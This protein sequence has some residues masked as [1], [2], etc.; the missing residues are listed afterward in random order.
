MYLLAKFARQYTKVLLTGEGADEVFLGYK[1]YL[2]KSI[3]SDDDLLFSNSFSTVDTVSGIIKNARCSL[4]EREK[5]IK[6]VVGLDYQDKLSF[7]DM[8]TYLPHV[9]LRQDKAG[10]AANIENRVPF[11]YESVVQAGYNLDLKIGKLGGKTPIKKIA[12]KYFSRDFVMREKCGFG[13]PISE[14]LKD[15]SGLLPHLQALKNS[16]FIS[17]YFKEKAIDKLICE[18]LNAIDDH[19]AVLFSLIGLDVWYNIFCKAPVFS[20]EKKFF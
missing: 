5:F 7:Y 18:H 6:E 10:M 17:E 1:R 12:M 11:L 13:L 14:W 3:T 2:K 16:R 9:L 20:Q 4:S 8:F 15:E 19:S